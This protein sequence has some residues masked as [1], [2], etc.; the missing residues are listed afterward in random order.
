M[1]TLVTGAAGFIGSHLSRRLLDDGHEVLGVDNFAPYYERSLKAANLLNLTDRRFRF[2][3]ADLCRTDT[4]ALLDGV[5]TVFHL[6]G[7]PGVRGSWGDTFADYVDANISATQRILEGALTA[8]GPRV[9][10][11]SSSSVYGD[12]PSFP[13][14]ETTNTRPRSPYGV[15]KLAGENLATLYAANYGLP[16]VSLRFFTVYGPRQR[17]DMAF[18]RFLRAAHDD[19]EITIYGNGEQIRDFTYVADIVDALVLAGNGD[20]PA[21]SVFNVAGGGSHSLNDVLEEISTIAGRRL[22]VRKQE[23]A[24]GDVVRTGGDTSA[25][26]AQFGWSPRVELREGLRDQWR[27][28]LETS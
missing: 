2:V 23:V 12:A 22:R 11:A 13:T 21:G 14:T 3:E 25:L 24:R 10:Y 7:Q 27:W 15:T 1:R 19:R 20:A 6:A 16:T 4:S 18:T 8:G 9:V 28:A 5:D 26:R 17:P